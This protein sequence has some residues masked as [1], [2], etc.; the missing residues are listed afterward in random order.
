MT[1]LSDSLP[2]LSLISLFIHFVSYITPETLNVN[3]V[4]HGFY[5]PYSWKV[6]HT[7]WQWKSAT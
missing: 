5:S 6:C 3:S 4:D 1:L 7:L 2:P